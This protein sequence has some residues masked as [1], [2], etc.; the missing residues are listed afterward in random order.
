[1][2]RFD[3]AARREFLTGREIV[4]ARA[5]AGALREAVFLVDADGRRRRLQETL[6]EFPAYLGVNARR[7]VPNNRERTLTHLLY[8]QLRAMQTPPAERIGPLERLIAIALAEEPAPAV[9]A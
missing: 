1:M 8:N 2:S 3:L 6:R 5:L 7:G 4:D 9:G